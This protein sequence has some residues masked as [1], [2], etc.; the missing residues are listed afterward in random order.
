MPQAAELGADVVVIVDG[1]DAAAEEVVR[2]HG[3]VLIVFPH[4]R[5]LNSGR[6]AGIEASQGE[7]VVFVDQD[8]EAPPGWLAALV[9][10]AR[11]YPEHDMFGGPIRARL[12]G[13]RRGCGR[14]PAP[15][16]TLDAGPEDCDVPLVWGANMAIRRRAFARLGPF[17]P[18]L[19]GRGDEEEFEYRY[20]AAGGAIRYLAAA[21]LDHRRA[22]ADATIP[23]LARAAYGQGREARRHDLRFGQARPRRARPAVPGSGASGTPCAGAAPT[24]SSWAPGPR[25]DCARPCFPRRR[26]RPG[27][28]LRGQRPG[29]RAAADRARADP[30]RRRETCAGWPRPSRSGWPAPR[31][32]G[33][34]RSVLVLAVERE[35]EP[36]VLAAARAELLRSRHEVH[37]HQTGVG[38]AGK[39]E[40][41]D[42]LLETHPAA[43]HDW[44]LVVDDDVRLPRGFLDGFI[45][46]AER[47]GLRLAQPAH[48]ARSHAAWSVTRRRAGQ[49]RA[50]DRIRRDRAGECVSR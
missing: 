47:F 31:A 5:G 45:F 3:A 8:I 42:R 1:P 9:A 38:T 33:P 32:S 12:E 2:R 18:E 49:R 43:G 13:A 44:L 48:R 26:E 19:L 27:L 25:A 50:R 35:D 20:T 14:E 16:T 34:R 22:R 23:A 15:I 29:R 37:F 39:F 4:Q 10:G 7:L 36:N 11:A 30:R 40:N 46:L 41:L 17:D 24:G 28:P 21:G 6:N